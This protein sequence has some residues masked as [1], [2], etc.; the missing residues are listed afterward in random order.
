MK[1]GTLPYYCLPYKKAFQDLHNDR[2]NIDGH[3]GGI[4]MSSKK[5]YLDLY[6][7]FD[8]ESFLTI[9]GGVDEIV[10]TTML[11]VQAKR[12][13]KDTKKKNG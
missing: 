5:A 11:S 8:T 12:A 7:T 13:K 3:I 10:I 1:L 2:L 4:P 9:I 6:P